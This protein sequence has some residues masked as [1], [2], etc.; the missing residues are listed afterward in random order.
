MST[1]VTEDPGH[2][3]SVVDGIPKS[4]S[5]LKREHQALQALGRELVELPDA[6]LRRLDLPD[7]IRE[8]VTTGRRL[9]RGALQR[10]LRHLGGMLASTD[11]ATIRAA[12]AALQAPSRA[13]VRRLHALEA[14]RDGL[15]RDGDDAIDALVARHPDA[16]RVRL[17]QLVRNARRE[18]GLAAS[19]RAARALFQF[20]K[21]LDGSET[22]GD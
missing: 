1:V 13:E 21:A 16:D 3:S 19:P 10:Q 18:A 4:R 14:L 22:A 8:A 5:Q 12:L 7:E 17:R 2:A 15:L 11:H 9:Q 20:L 6:V